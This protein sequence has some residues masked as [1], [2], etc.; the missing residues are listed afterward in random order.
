MGLAAPATCQA[1]QSVTYFCSYCLKRVPAAS[2]RVTYHREPQHVIDLT[3]QLLDCPACGLTLA[4]VVQLPE[5]P[6]PQSSTAPA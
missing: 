4:A 3:S 5:L 1:D 2:A 6:V